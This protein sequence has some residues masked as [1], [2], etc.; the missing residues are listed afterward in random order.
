MK[1]LGYILNLIM[2]LAMR[3]LTS[4]VIMGWGLV[5]LGV[6]LR[7]GSGWWLATGAVI[8][9]FGAMVLIGSPLVRRFLYDA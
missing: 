8:A 5:T 9:L 7:E 6:G 1:R 3:L 2:S 4:L